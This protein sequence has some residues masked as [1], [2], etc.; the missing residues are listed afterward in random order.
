MT[1]LLDQLVGVLLR[2]PV[3][4]RLRWLAAHARA[5]RVRGRERRPPAPL[6]WTH[7]VMVRGKVVS[8]R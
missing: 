2:E 3:R 4:E 1:F 6:R 5:C 7:A 8:V